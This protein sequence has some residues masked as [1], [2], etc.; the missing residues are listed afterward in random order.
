MTGGGAQRDVGGCGSPH[1]CRREG[2]MAKSANYLKLEERWRRGEPTVLDGGIGSELQAMGYPPGEPGRARNFTWGALALYEAPEIV[3][4]MHRRYVDAGAD[5]LMTNTFL[6][7]R[8]VRLEADGELPVT[9][10]GWREK[11]RLAVRLAR[12]AAR[13]GGRPDSAVLFSMMIQ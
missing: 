5:S 8:C 1:R 4:A 9:G 7:H 2:E 6:F 3:K 10:D 11:A 12:E 13:E